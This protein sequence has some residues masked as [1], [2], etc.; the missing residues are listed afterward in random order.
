[1]LNATDVSTDKQQ[2]HANETV[3]SNVHKSIL[4][5]WAR[6]LVCK[7]SPSKIVEENRATYKQNTNQAKVKH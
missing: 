5:L 1:M 2:T 3:I 7:P 6:A 4:G